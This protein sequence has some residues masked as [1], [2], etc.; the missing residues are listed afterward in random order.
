MRGESTLPAPPR[1]SGHRRE[2]RAGGHAPAVAVRSNPRFAAG[3]ISNYLARER[4]RSGSIAQALLSA[5]PRA[6]PVPPQYPPP[7]RRDT[8][9]DSSEHQGNSLCFADSRRA[10]G[11]ESRLSLRALRR[12]GCNITFDIEIELDFCVSGEAVFL[13][14]LGVLNLS[15]IAVVRTVLQ[16]RQ[17]VA[18]P[19]SF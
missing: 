8:E 6:S 2:A 10:R 14:K 7:I 5:Q 12:G 19:H 11:S 3:S 9:A 4:T 17:Q 16:G 13:Q 1:H 18:E 15:S